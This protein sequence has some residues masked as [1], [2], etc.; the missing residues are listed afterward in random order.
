MKRTA[1]ASS[2]GNHLTSRLPGVNEKFA[3]LT[4]GAAALEDLRLLSNLETDRSRLIQIVLMGQP[5]W[6]EELISPSCASS[7]SE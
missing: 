3:M 4:P 2:N 5:S 7:S 1:T 6:S